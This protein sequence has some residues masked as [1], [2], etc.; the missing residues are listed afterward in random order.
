MAKRLATQYV[1]ACFTVTEAELRTFMQLFADH[2]VSLQMKVF[3]NGNQELAFLENQDGEEGTLTFERH[4]GSYLVTG[5]F[6]LIRPALVN[7]MRKAVADFK[8]DALVH[9][10]YNGYVMVYHYTQGAVAKIEEVRGHERKLIFEYKN[11]VGKLE[12]LYRKQDVEEEIMLIR[13]DI[14]VLLDRRNQ[15]ADEAERSRID[16]ELRK[17]TR[18]LFILEA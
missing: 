18:R 12:Q 11:T 3:D 14:N 13:M 1:K 7:A 15:A 4:G 10:I 2:Q 17:M 5:S 6:R 9:R 16:S 8:G